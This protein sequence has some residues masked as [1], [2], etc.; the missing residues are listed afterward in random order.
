MMD[1][2]KAY[3]ERLAYK[4]FINKID[5]L[6]D[7]DEKSILIKL[8]QLFALTVIEEDKGWYLEADY[9]EGVKT[10][11]IRRMIS[12]LCQELRYEARGLVDAFGIPEELLDAKVVL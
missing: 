2:A 9:M 4:E 3:I 7:S 5:A 11:A 6:E 8:S 12:K 10:K 1:L